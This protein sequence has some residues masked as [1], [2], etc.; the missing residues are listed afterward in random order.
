LMLVAG[1]G[2]ML[3]S[4]Y[5]LVSEGVGFDT[6][7]LVT[8]ELNLPVQRYASEESQSRFFHSLLDRLRALPG[9]TM[10]SVVD[11]LPLHRIKLTG[12]T[13]EGRPEQPGAATPLAISPTW[14]RNSSAFSG[15][16]SCP[17]ACSRMPIWRK[18][19]RMG[20]E[21]RW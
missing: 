4:F 9:V 17:A 20:T 18:R 12:F 6:G 21:W 13:I 16:G 2:L 5:E 7:H 3:R 1:A 15:C 10:A 8:L 11:N 19:R 14:I